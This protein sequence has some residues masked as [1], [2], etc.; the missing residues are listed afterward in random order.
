[1]PQAVQT[2]TEL[3]ELLVT[4]IV[5]TVGGEEDDWRTAV[6]EIEK[7]PIATNVRSNWRIRPNGTTAQKNVIRRAGKVV[8]AAYPYVAS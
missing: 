5:G 1:M 4:I 6:G 3:R 7:L 8:R 2:P